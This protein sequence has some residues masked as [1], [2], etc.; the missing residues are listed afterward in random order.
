ML[1]DWLFKNDNFI[2][3]TKQLRLEDVK[4]FSYL[5]CFH[6]DIL[7]FLRH[8]LAGVKKYLLGDKDENIPRNVKIYNRMK[9]V[10]RTLKALPYI[11]AFYYIFVKHD[12]I[13]VC[14]SYFG[15]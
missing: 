1:N 4:S 7:L 15:H 11:V 9:F 3:L 8:A 14:K 12:L 6:Y 13:H 2:S 5:D 10:D